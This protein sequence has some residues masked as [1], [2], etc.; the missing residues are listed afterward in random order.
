TAPIRADHPLMVRRLHPLLEPEPDGV[1]LH[2]ACGPGAT[3]A[4]M[5]R[6]LGAW[7]V[8]RNGEQTH[9][10]GDAL[11]RQSR[12][13]GRHHRSE[14]FTLYELQPLGSRGEVQR[15]LL[16]GFRSVPG[17]VQARVFLYERS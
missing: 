4:W 6:A 7:R 11:N 8:T 10:L 1:I 12:H 2:F 14:A 15:I 3:I 13:G 17:G 9:L 16:D 5:G